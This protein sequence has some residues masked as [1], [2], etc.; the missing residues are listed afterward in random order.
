MSVLNAR[1]TV[2]PGVLCCGGRAEVTIS[3]DVEAE[4]CQ[5]PADMVLVLDRS[6]SMYGPAMA[7]VKTAAREL[8]E[9]VARSSGDPRGLRI[10]NGSHL[11]IV[12]FAGEARQDTALETDVEVL[13]RGIE[14]LRA[15]GETNHEL[16]FREAE[17]MLDCSRAERKLMILFTDGMSNRGNADPVAERLKSRGIEIFCIGLLKNPGVLNRWA[18]DPASDHVASTADPC[19]LGSLF[20]EIGSQVVRTGVRDVCI[21]ETLTDDFRLEHLNFISQGTVRV[22]S[23]RCLKWDVGTVSGSGTVSL[24]FTVCHVGSTWG[25]TAVN[26]SVCYEDREGNCLCFP[27]PTVEILGDCQDIIGDPCP[28]PTTFQVEPCQDLAEVTAKDLTISG[29]GRIVRVNAMLKHVCPGRRVALA[30]VLTEVDENGTEY[31]RG[32]KTLLIPA[33]E[34]E[35]CRDIQI[36][37]IQFIV[38]E[39]LD[40]SGNPEAMCGSRE[41]RVRL[42]ANYVDTDFQCCDPEAVIL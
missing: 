5:K 27:S 26:E 3:F 14:G 40:V 36:R 33:Q 25:R 39:E 22:C 37:C 29:Q 20:R 32:M 41:F 31:A 7:M 23:P 8:I 21:L 15:R 17:R 18:S 24:R 1:K 13:S 6:G 42:S 19:Q 9:T 2:T 4:L 11:G 38:P 16:A 12:S 34:G 28:D 35:G 30:A 10:L